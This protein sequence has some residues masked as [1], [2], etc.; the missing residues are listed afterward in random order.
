MDIKHRFIAP[1]RHQ[2]MG[3]VERYNRT[4]EDRIRKLLYAHGG[5]WVDYV[6]TAE[7]EINQ[8]VSST[9]GFSPLELWYGTKE[10]RKLARE[11]ADKMRDAR[12]QKKKVFSVRFFEGQMVLI[13]ETNPGKQ[14]KFDRKWKGPYVVKSRISDTMWSV[15]KGIR[16]QIV[17]VHEDQMQPFD[18]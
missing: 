7:H 6:K 15:Q 11:R 13:R 8:A 9:T 10:M 2:S 18:L 16:D 1:Y 14:R 12:N 3:L 5:S 17:I 4:I